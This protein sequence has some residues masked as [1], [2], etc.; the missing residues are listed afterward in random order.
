MLSQSLHD[1][2]DTHSLTLDEPI[3]L[4]HTKLFIIIFSNHFHHNQLI[5][6]LHQVIMVL[7]TCRKQVCS[8]SQ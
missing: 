1:V 4:V 5:I 2:G 6:M 3:K 7:G 8:H